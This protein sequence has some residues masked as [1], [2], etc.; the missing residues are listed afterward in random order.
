MA[1]VSRQPN[2]GKT[3]QVRCPDGKRRSIRLG[4]VTMKDARL[5]C[6]HVEQLVASRISGRQPEEVTLKWLNQ[7]PAKF[8]DKLQKYG[9][10][11]AKPSISLGGFLEEHFHRNRKLHK[12]TLTVWRQT[13]RNLIECFGADRDLRTLREADADDLRLFLLREDLAEATRNRRSGFA[14]QFMNAAIKRGY[15]DFNP[16]LSLKSGHVVNEARQ[17]FIERDEIAKVMEACTDGEFRLIVALS[18]YGGLRCP[19][20]TL[21]LRWE[22]IDF[23]GGAM[24]VREGKTSERMVPLFVELRPYLESRRAK[25]GPVITTYRTVESNLRTRMRRAIK[26]AGLEPWPKTFHNL[27]A[28]RETE[29]L[30]EYPMHV[31]VKWIGNSEPVAM[32]HYAMIRDEDFQRASGLVPK[33]VRKV[34]KTSENE[35]TSDHGGDDGNPKRI[36]SKQKGHLAE[37]GPMDGGGFDSDDASG[38]MDSDS[39]DSDGDADA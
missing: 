10:T 30:G 37:G 16:F 20:E 28:S 31:V 32:K 11:D 3:V 13:K 21:S 22:D 18:R 29:L 4:K 6:G 26:R 33:A 12:G 36:D 8:V 38:D 19:S 17:Q 27:R 23:D 1:S 14:K 9:L 24:L 2:G 35:W 7:L 25:S 34:A 5:F 15:L 39:V